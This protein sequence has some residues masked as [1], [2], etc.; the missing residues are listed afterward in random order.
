M[1]PL[2]YS[3]SGMS[4]HASI[5]SNENYVDAVDMTDAIR[6]GTGYSIYYLEYIPPAILFAHKEECT[7]SSPFLGR[8]IHNLLFAIQLSVAVMSYTYLCISMQEV[9]RCRVDIVAR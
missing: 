5:K 8:H 9:Q 6:K 2:H 1:F 3:E 4:G 7:H